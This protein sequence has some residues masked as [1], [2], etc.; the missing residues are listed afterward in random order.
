[1][2]QEIKRMIDLLVAPIKMLPFNND[3]KKG[4]IDMAETIIRLIEIM[5]NKKGGDNANDK[6]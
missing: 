4:Q 5:E 2:L 3:Y 1:M 6:G